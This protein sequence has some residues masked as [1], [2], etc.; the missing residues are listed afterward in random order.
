MANK[1]KGY[2]RWVTH[3]GW[4]ICVLFVVLAA[5]V[6]ERISDLPGVDRK[7][8]D[9][10]KALEKEPEIRFFMFWHNISPLFAT[11]RYPSDSR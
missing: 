8:E 3:A 11:N 1:T 7:L 10:V 9:E 6:S 4:L 5:R 2:S